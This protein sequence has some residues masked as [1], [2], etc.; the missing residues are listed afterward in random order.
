M[1]RNKKKKKKNKEL[2]TTAHYVPLLALDGVDDGLYFLLKTAGRHAV[3]AH[4]DALRLRP[5]DE[6]GQRLH[7]L[8]L[9]GGVDH[10]AGV[11][12]VAPKVASFVAKVVS[13]VAPLLLS[14]VK[15]TAV[16]KDYDWSM[17][18]M[19]NEYKYIQE[20]KW[21]KSEGA[22]GVGE[23]GETSTQMQAKNMWALWPQQPMNRLLQ[24]MRENSGLAQKID[25]A[26]LPM[27][28]EPAIPS[29]AESKDDA[30]LPRYLE[31]YPDQEK[32]KRAKQS[33]SLSAR[34]RSTFVVD[35][36]CVPRWR[37]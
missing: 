21:D 31:P 14:M 25:A 5:L 36:P 34:V 24:D 35:A 8:L 18:S 9:A 12:L 10:V 22:D 16:P 13:A 19:P 11:V 2:A 4:R 7:L 30:A 28:A 20:Y 27:K 6:R 32:L 29:P 1:D 37:V 26:F 33:H 17:G 15:A 23:K 3:D